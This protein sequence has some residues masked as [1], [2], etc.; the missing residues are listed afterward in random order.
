MVVVVV[1]VVIVVVD[2]LLYLVGVFGFFWSNAVLIL[3]FFV[4]FS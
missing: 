3:N 4:P 2:M 1:V